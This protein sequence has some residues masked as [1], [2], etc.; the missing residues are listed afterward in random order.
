MIHG[1]TK[2]ELYNPN[3]KIKQI[4]REEN[5][6]QSSVLASYMRSLG[7][8]NNNPFANTTF[9]GTKSWQNLVG[10]ILL[11]KNSIDLSGGDVK[12]MPSGNQMIANGSFGVS[13]GA[14]A[15]DPTEM[16]S[17]NANESSAS[18]SA[19]TQVYDWETNQGNGTIGCIALTSQTGGY[20]G[21]GNESGTS[22]SLYDFKRNQ[23]QQQVDGSNTNVGYSTVVGNKKYSFWGVSGDNGLNLI[24]R[25]TNISVTQGSIFNGFYSDTTFD[26]SVIG[27][28]GNISFGEFTPCV[29]GTNIYLIPFDTQTIESG[30]KGY[31]Y[32]YDTTN[33]TLT[34][35]EFT[36]SSSITIRFGYSTYSNYKGSRATVANGL[37]FAANENSKV[38]VF[39]LSD[40][41]Y[42]QELNVN[43]ASS[44]YMMNI[45][46]SGHNGI[47]FVHTNSQEMIYDTST[48]A[49]RITNGNAQINPSAFIPFSYDSASDSLVLSNGSPYLYK[50]PLYLATINNLQSPVTKTAAQT[51]KVTYTLTES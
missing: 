19:I 20:I 11:F 12:Y 23:N 22:K 40:G 1:K 48:G 37:L 41:S 33:N 50:S 17:Y 45:A 46:G 5:T 43:T 14:S 47:V 3:T 9:R 24:V 25:K 30:A 49:C 31:F 16:G 13:N 8:A 29:D 4:I 42:I 7:E 21:Y 6:F 39:K 38:C 36:N 10:G 15:D 34:E 44:I 26:L 18:G 2:I 32:K 51:M 35:V 27:N 28:H